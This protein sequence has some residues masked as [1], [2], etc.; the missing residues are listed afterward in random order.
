MLLGY[1]TNGFA[2]H[3]IEDALDIIEELGYRSVGFTVDT[4][5]PYSPGLFEGRNLVPVIETGARFLLDPRCKHEPTLMSDAGREKRLD[6]YYRCI[7]IAAECGAP[8]VSLWSGQ[9]CDWKRLVDGLGRV[10]DRAD[11]AG[12]DIAFEPEPGMLVDT[13]AAFLVLHDLLPHPRLGLTLDVGHLVCLGEG[14]PAEIVRSQAGVLRNVHLD[15]HRRGAHEHLM[16]GAGEVDWPPLLEVL[17]E[18]D[19]PA[20]VELSRHSHNAVATARRSLAFLTS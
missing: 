5:H 8:C 10:C 16:F 4:N 15:D 18:L 17:A 9:G 11:A 3:R 1:N 7:D 6:F 2:H 12:V 19:V 13:T 14:D 20:T